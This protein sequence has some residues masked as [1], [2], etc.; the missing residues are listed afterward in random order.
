MPR[1]TLATCLALL[2]TGTALAAPL[3]DAI[4]LYKDKKNPEARAALETITTAEPQNAEACY[5]LGLTLLRTRDPK[6]LESAVGWFKK[7]AELQPENAAYLFEYGGNSLN[8]AGKTRSLGAANRGRDALE[9]VIKL[10]PA[11][12]NA[13]EALYQFFDQA[14]W[15]IG[16][17]SK[18]KAHLDEIR[19]RDPDYANTILI[20][21]KTNSKNY[22]EAFK[23]CDELLA[24]TPES[25]VALLL[26]G[27]AAILS[28]QNLDSALAG[29]KKCLTLTPPPKAPGYAF[30]HWRIGNVLEKKGDKP[31]ARAAYEASLQADT[32]FSMATTALE[33]LK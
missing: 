15:P 8:L 23:L 6:L 33:K 9:K 7:A 2:F 21:T 13:H 5:Y 29:L 22:T 18:A 11:H 19:K 10:D 30:V 17:G 20:T 24:K 1:R 12:L 16:S 25:Y 4:A 14:P 3:D 28:G 32:N 27:R 31:A 26:Y